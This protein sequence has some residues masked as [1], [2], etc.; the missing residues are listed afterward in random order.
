M[1]ASTSVNLT[2][3]QAPP[4]SHH[5]IDM[6]ILQAK[7]ELNTNERESLVD[8]AATT[9]PRRNYRHPAA[10]LRR[11]NTPLVDSPASVSKRTYHLPRHPA[12]FMKCC[13]C[14][15]NQTVT[16]C[17]LSKPELR[18]DDDTT[19]CRACIRAAAASTSP[20]SKNTMDKNNINGDN[21]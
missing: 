4:E 21:E 15:K 14:N 5:N 8:K 9:A 2:P 6:M 17:G 16:W 11:N 13:E 10:V 19:T 18:G 20:S 12:D 1:M 7:A 3:R